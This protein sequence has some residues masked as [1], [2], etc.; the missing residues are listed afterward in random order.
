MVAHW[1]GLH[2]GDLP[3]N[4]VTLNAAC[5]ECRRTFVWEDGTPMNEYNGWSSNVRP[6]LYD[7]N[8][9]YRSGWND[10]HCDDEYQFICERFDGKYYTNY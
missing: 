9:L 2:R 1:I 3:C 6:G 10:E 5:L 7:C 4:C 8:V